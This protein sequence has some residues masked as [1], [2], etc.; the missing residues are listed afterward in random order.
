MP[1][2]EPRTS[3]KR[4][5]RS[6]ALP[7]TTHH[8]HKTSS[9][10]L[11]SKHFTHTRTMTIEV[12]STIPSG[13]FAFVDNVDDDP[14]IC[15]KPQQLKTDEWKGKKIVLF[16]V[17]GA[18]TP[19]CSE[20]HLPGYLEGFEKLQS[21]GVDAVYCIA[22]NDV[23]VV[24]AWQR[25]LKAGNKLTCISDA[26]LTWLEAAGLVQDLSHVGFGKRS[27]R[28]AAII[29]DLKVEYIGIEEGGGVTVSGAEA[30]LAKL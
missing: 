4:S 24:S 5:L 19:T 29:N 13:T 2:C 6:T 7:H 9:P 1:P 15:G 30:V 21:K 23:F 28:F 8:T 11:H 27:K 3:W 14:S 17:P 10:P 12:G 20:A 26:T 16:G 18:F 25:A 22:S